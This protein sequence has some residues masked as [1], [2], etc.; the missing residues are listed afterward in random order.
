V[1]SKGAKENWNEKGASRLL[2]VASE[3]PMC[4]GQSSDSPAER[5][6][7]RKNILRRL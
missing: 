2:C 5:A 6:V 7:L 4:T 3:S 1:K